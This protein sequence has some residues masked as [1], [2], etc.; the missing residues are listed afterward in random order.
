MKAIS[1]S[2]KVLSNGNAAH[3]VIPGAPGSFHPEMDRWLDDI[4]NG[5]GFRRGRSL[6]FLPTVE[7]Q[8]LDSEYRV[9]VD[10]PGVELNNIELTFGE[11]LLTLKAE[12]PAD[13]CEALYSTRWSGPFERV[14]GVGPD[15]DEAGIG[16]RLANGVLTI[17]LPKKPECRP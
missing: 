6:S 5:F 11:G 10:L 13:G 3:S 7:L 8:E 17:T 15:V 16:A 14:V 1:F 12:R 2:P 9:V 4:S